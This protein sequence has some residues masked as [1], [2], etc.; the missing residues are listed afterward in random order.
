MKSKNMNTSQQEHLLSMPVINIF[1]G[2]SLYHSGDRGVFSCFHCPTH[3]RYRIDIS[4]ICIQIL[5]IVSVWN[6]LVSPITNHRTISESI[7]VSFPDLSPLLSQ[8]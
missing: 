8:I 6:L 2:Q 1:G 3:I 5:S 4:D 7:V